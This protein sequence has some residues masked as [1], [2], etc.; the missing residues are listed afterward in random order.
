M[1]DVVSKWPAS[2]FTAPALGF[3]AIT[4]SDTI[5]DA[6]GPFKAI[7][8]GA[9]GNIAVVGL[10]NV[11][12]TFVGAIAGSILPIVGRRINATNTTA[13]SLVGLR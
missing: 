9:A 5:D 11:A 6:A 10:G 7:Y 3:S 2:M 12:V 8:V 4:P 13:T 1:V